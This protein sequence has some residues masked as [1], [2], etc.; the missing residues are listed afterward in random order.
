MSGFTLQ[1]SR[2]IP[3]SASVLSPRPPSTPPLNPRYTPC[4][5]T[6]HSPPF[7]PPPN[8]RRH[9]PRPP[10]P[11]PIGRD[12][13]PRHTSTSAKHF[14]TRSI[15]PD[16]RATATAAPAVVALCMCSLVCI[17]CESRTRLFGCAP[18]QKDRGSNVD[19]LSAGNAGRRALPLLQRRRGDVRRG[20]KV[21]HGSLCL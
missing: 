21:P 19:A 16:G 9:R 17:R 20:A 12:S 7:L 3:P 2:T 18:H 5:H 15:F 6:P 14:F 1:W 8:T 10:P 13:R 4:L 11:P